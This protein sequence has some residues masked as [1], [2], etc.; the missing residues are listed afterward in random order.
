VSKRQPDNDDRAQ[1]LLY[2][3]IHGDA[4]AC[5][6]FGVTDRSL[7]NW[8]TSVRE[9]GDLSETFR[10]YALALAPEARAGEF[11]AWVEGDI[12]RASALFFEK[13]SPADVSGKN[14]EVL[15][16]ITEHLAALLDHKTALD[17]L[18]LRFG[19]AGTEGTSPTAP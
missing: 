19:T 18:A 17:F 2:A 6:R 13:V 7:R 4:A 16:A 5:A 11:A 15:R 3:T 8:R 1:I 12:R 10:L 9:G 14:P